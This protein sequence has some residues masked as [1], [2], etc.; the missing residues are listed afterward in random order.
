V[1]A[2]TNG[3]GKKM[4]MAMVI[5]F[6]EWAEKIWQRWLNDRNHP[7]VVMWSIGNEIKE[8]AM[9]DGYKTARFWLKF[10]II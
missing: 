4:P 2:L 6:D 7:S 9:T 5:F 3:K 10:V 1:E 8:Q